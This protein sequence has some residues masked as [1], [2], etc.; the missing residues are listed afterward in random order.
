MSHLKILKRLEA[1]EQS[2]ARLIEKCTRLELENESL[3]IENSRLKAKVKDLEAK[4]A[5]YEVKKDSTNSSIPPSQDPNRK[6]NT[7]LRKPSGKKPG[8]QPGHKGHHLKMS[9]SPDTIVPHMPHACAHCSH[10]LSATQQEVHSRYQIVDIPPV[11][12]VITEHVVYEAQCPCCGK[13]T[14]APHERP[15]KA[16]VSYGERLDSLVGYLNVRQYMPY[17]RIVEMLSVCYNIEISE[18]TVRNMLMRLVQ[19]SASTYDDLHKQ[20]STYRVLGS[21]E[22]SM[23]V[24]GVL[25]WLWTWQ[26]EAITFLAAATSRGYCVIEEL[27]EH[28]LEQ[29]ILVSD[30]L[31][32]QLKQK[33]AGHQICLAHLLRDLKHAIQSST[34]T[35]WLQSFRKL[36]LDTIALKKEIDYDRLKDY[37]AAIHELHQRK[38]NLIDQDLKDGTHAYS[39][40]KAM[41]KVRPHLLTCLTE[42]EVPPDNNGSERAL[43]NAKVKQKVSTMFKN[44]SGMDAFARLRTIIDTGVKRGL[45]PLTVLAQ[46]QLLIAE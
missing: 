36:L 28:G 11:R 15:H 14:V 33:V 32:A 22:T 16:P 39:F 13:K 25:H 41:R 29:C 46:P 30:R 35:V 1:L 23:N 31:A 37:Q 9:D 6:K 19:R 26:N 34:D 17:N 20:L 42:K 27:F 10:D 21:D 7:S 12:P 5:K 44:M 18:G 8:G 40:Q 3:K 2:H 43:R 24:N 45:D 4:L 38:E